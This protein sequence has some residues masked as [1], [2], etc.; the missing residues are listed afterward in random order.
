MNKIELIETLMDECRI[1]K[2]EAAAIVD[3]F[4]DKIS[5]ALAEGD[6]LK[7]A[8]YALSLL[9]NFSPIKAGIPKPGRPLP[10]HPND[11]HFSK[12]GKN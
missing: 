8:G 5:T 11:C 7:S 1:S 4:F 2:K 12:L 6:R 10:W 9:K 3:I